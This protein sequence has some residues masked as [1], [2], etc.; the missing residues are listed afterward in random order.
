MYIRH[1]R[2]ERVYFIHAN[3]FADMF[4]VH[5]KDEQA[6]LLFKMHS[7][8]EGRC[9][10]VMEMMNKTKR[11]GSVTR[12]A[13]ELRKFWPPKGDILD[14]IPLRTGDSVGLLPFKMPNKCFIYPSDEDMLRQRNVLLD[15][16]NLEASESKSN[17]Y[18]GT[19]LMLLSDR[20]IVCYSNFPSQG[21]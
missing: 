9:S 13:V 6:R 11:V 17:T 12:S 3:I 7:I 4:C 5:K 20:W 16:V 15:N 8:E 18:S 2:T 21:H 14:F 19:L 1:F 10:G